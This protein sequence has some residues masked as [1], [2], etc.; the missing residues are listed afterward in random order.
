MA[1][2]FM[3]RVATTKI[4]ILLKA[5][6]PFQ[7]FMHK[8]LLDRS[9]AFHFKRNNNITATTATA[10]AAA[11]TRMAWDMFQQQICS[12]APRSTNRKERFYSSLFRFILF[13]FSFCNKQNCIITAY[14][15]GTG[16]QQRE[17]EKQTKHR[18]SY[19]QHDLCG[20]KIVC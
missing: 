5:A 10:A 1:T 19:V 11:S 12:T 2:L 4:V 13:N 17:K 14:S 8:H 7:P 16:T 20:Y 3:C 18:K 9:D 6:Q 15:C